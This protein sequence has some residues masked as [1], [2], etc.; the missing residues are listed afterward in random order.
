MGRRR[1]C[2]DDHRLLHAR[3]ARYD[4]EMLRSL[5]AS[6]AYRSDA[7]S[8]ARQ[9]LIT[10]REHGYREL[11]SGAPRRLDAAADARAVEPGRTR[12]VLAL[13]CFAMLVAVA[14]LDRL[15]S[16]RAAWHEGLWICGI[17]VVLLGAMAWLVTRARSLHVVCLVGFLVALVGFLVELATRPSTSTLLWP[18][19]GSAVL[20]VVLPWALAAGQRRDARAAARREP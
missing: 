19:I 20:V 16:G 6:D 17:A 9:I 8:V 11:P 12:G 2:D 13:S 14:P 3:L 10:R 18:T 7:K 5:L 1:T 15:A 4:D